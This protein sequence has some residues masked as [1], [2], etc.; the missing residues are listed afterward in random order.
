MATI[1]I[2]S[3][4]NQL[5]LR[6]GFDES[7]QRVPV[8]HSAIREIVNAIPIAH[9]ISRFFVG[10]VTWISGRIVTASQEERHRHDSQNQKELVL[11]HLPPLFRFH[12]N[13]SI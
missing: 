6:M 4:V 13:Y 8:I 12:R 7:G 3:R 9:H 2:A 10:D 5:Q 1:A 11:C